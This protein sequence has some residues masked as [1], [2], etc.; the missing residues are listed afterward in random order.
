[1]GSTNPRT[2]KQERLGEVVL[3][4]VVPNSTLMLPVP[5]LSF[6]IKE[7]ET[8]IVSHCAYLNIHDFPG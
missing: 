5:R 8:V 2:L 1:M 4:P 3:N 7:H 6:D